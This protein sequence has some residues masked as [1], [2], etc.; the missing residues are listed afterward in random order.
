MTLII[1]LQALLP[2]AREEV[3]VAQ[4]RVQEKGLGL[5]QGLARE[6]LPVTRLVAAPLLA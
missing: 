5:V 3:E 2:T 4:A 1:I 6:L